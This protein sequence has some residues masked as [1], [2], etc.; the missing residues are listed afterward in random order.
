MVRLRVERR[1]GKPFSPKIMEK[2]RHW[3]RPL[4]RNP[5]QRSFKSPPPL[6]PKSLA[7][8]DTCNISPYDGAIILAEIRF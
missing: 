2:N 4:R 6:G 8:L 7:N 1:F 3:E 5:S